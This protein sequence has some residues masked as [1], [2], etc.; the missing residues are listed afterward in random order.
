MIIQVF[1]YDSSYI[2]DIEINVSSIFIN[3]TRAIN[4]HC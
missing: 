3:I 2:L 4:N 1:I